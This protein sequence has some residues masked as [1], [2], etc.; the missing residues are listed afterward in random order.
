M[1][2]PPIFAQRN[3]CG[4]ISVDPFRCINSSDKEGPPAAPIQL[5]Q[6]QLCISQVQL[7]ELSGI[8]SRLGVQ[9]TS[10]AL[11]NSAF[12]SIS[13]MFVEKGN[14]IKFSNSV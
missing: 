7:F 13:A 14:N 12:S 8:K 11:S 5:I 1:P 3:F 2:C 9:N 10:P 4:E 6:S